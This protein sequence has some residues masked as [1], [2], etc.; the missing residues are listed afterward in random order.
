MGV[1]WLLMPLLWLGLIALIVWA[2]LRLTQ[3]R[4][5]RGR[6]QQTVETPA[7]ILDRRFARGEID[8]EAY[9]QAR[10]ALGLSGPS[11]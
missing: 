4:G 10:E 5:E 6:V 8:D 3:D 7:D 9:R 2:V 11:R 1:G